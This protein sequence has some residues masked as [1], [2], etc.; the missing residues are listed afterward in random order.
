[1]FVYPSDAR[2]EEMLRL[3]KC[4][5]FE[6]LIWSLEDINGDRIYVAVD[7][8]PDYGEGEYGEETIQDDGWRQSDI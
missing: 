4:I 1:V 5:E 3:G 2:Y 8:C 7:I 6:G